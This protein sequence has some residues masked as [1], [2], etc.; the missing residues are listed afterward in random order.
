MFCVKLSL[1]H[2]AKNIQRDGKLLEMKFFLS[3]FTNTAHCHPLCM[4]K[5]PVDWWIMQL[6]ERFV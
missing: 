1:G 5:I 3:V 2:N 6:T 4:Y